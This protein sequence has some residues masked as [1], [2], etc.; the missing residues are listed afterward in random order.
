MRTWTALT[1]SVARGRAEADPAKDPPVLQLGGDT[2]AAAALAGA[3]GV[4]VFRCL[5]RRPLE[6][7]VR[8]RL[9]DPVDLDQQVPGAAQRGILSV[10]RGVFEEPWVV[11]PTGEFY[12]C[13]LRFLAGESGAEAVVNTGE[14]AEVLVVLPFWIEPVRI[15]E[16]VRVSVGGGQREDDAR[17]LRNRDLPDLNVIQ[18]HVLRVD[19]HRRLVAQQLLDQR[20]R[21]L[22]L[23]A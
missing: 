13:D 14:E 2:L 20:D 4:D 10:R 5:L 15:G 21:Q 11:Q 8:A 9:S 3:S 6:R 12:E 1:S 19:L 18:G 22:G 16:S 23:V 17:A 7:I